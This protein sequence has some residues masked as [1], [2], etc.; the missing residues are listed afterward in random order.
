MAPSDKTALLIEFFCWYGDELW[1]ADADVLLSLALPVLGK[2]H[3]VKKSEIIN[4][5]VHR[6]RYA[7]PVYDL[8]YKEHSGKVLGYLGRFKNLQLIGRGGRFRYNNID[9]AM[10]TG[11]LAAQSILEGRFFDLD[12]AGTEKAYF[13][14]G[15]LG[16]AQTG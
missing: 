6:E 16:R 11:M 9:H 5:F 12:E 1:N 4:Y 13:E 15:F 8:N 7:Y 3:F 10:E 14:R 2:E